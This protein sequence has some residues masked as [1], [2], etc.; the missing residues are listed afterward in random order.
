MIE[1]CTNPVWTVD[2][3][4]IDQSDSSHQQAQRAPVPSAETALLPAGPHSPV[5][6]I[7][8]AEAGTS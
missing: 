5:Q 8:M 7:S 6:G 4:M 2:E 1:Q 3:I